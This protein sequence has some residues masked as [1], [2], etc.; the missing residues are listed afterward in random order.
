[1]RALTSHTV[2]L[3]SENALAEITAANSTAPVKRDE[4]DV[5]QEIWE[6]MN[7]DENDILYAG[8]M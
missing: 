4:R 8:K 5:L 7:D 2:R 3:E 6:R 1:M